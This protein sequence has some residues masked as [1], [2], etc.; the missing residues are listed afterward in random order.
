LDV[1]TTPVPAQAG[2]AGLEAV[3]VAA[4]RTA[5]KGM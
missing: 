5:L 4:A 2:N 3:M 1:D